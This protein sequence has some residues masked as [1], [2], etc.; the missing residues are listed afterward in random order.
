MQWF[1]FNPSLGGD[2]MNSLLMA[3]V[4][5]FDKITNLVIVCAYERREAYDN[6]LRRVFTDHIHQLRIT[7]DEFSRRSCTV[8]GAMVDDYDIRL[9]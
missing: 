2:I 9:C 1:G 4:I 5:G 8:V 6:G 7:L 3:P